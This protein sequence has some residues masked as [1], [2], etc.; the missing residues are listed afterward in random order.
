MQKASVLFIIAL[1]LQGCAYAVSPGL[2]D[3]ADT[4]ISFEQLQADPDSFQGKLLIL[5]GTIA[6]TTAVKKGTLIEI[7]QKPLDYWGKPQRT[8]RTGGRF[9]AFTPGYLNT[10]VYAPGIDITIAGEVLGVRSPMLGEKQYDYPVVLVKEL[11]RW[12]RESRSRD[13]APWMDPL[14]NPTS[15]GRPE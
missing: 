3:K 2:A 9:F 7:D 10:M 15:S 12:E 8:R 14:N 5:G 6:Q 11:K 4:T 13:K 1:F